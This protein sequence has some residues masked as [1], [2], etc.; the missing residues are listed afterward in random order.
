MRA[1]KSDEQ[2]GNGRKFWKEWFKWS[3]RFC[4]IDTPRHTH[5]TKK[6][7][8]IHT[9][10]EYR[11]WFGY[12]RKLCCFFDEIE[13]WVIHTFGRLN[14]GCAYRIPQYIHSIFTVFILCIPMLQW[15]VWLWLTVCVVVIFVVAVV[16][17]VDVLFL[18]FCFFQF[19]LNRESIKCVF[20]TFSAIKSR[21]INI[22]V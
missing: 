17:V 3:A 19:W 7:N 14:T 10:R 8:N 18:A 2:F 1:R 22:D 21:R 20:A 9:E 15:S 12:L 4:E 16:V 6:N 13:W 11:T 5:T